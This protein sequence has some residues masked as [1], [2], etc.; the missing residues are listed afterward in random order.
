LRVLLVDDEAAVLSAVSRMLHVYEPS[1]EVRTAL[2]ADSA[3]QAL[4]EQPVDVVV[5]DV[6]MPKVPG[7]RF[8]AEVR[9]LYPGL[10]RILLTGHADRNA[11]LRSIGAAHRFLRK[12]CEPEELVRA[13]SE[14]YALRSLLNHPG[15]ERVAG[16]AKSLPAAPS[17]YIRLRQELDDPMCSAERVGTIMAMD[18]AMSAKVLQLV[19]SSFFGLAKAVTS[20][21]QACMVLGTDTLSSIVAMTDGFSR[22]GS[23]VVGGLSIEELQSHSLSVGTLSRKIAL[24]RPE[25]QAFGETAFLAGLLH[26]AGKLLLATAQK[27]YARILKA[28]IASKTPIDTIER[29]MW[30]SGHGEVGAYLLGL[31]GLPDPVVEAVAFHHRPLEAPSSGFNLASCVYLGD[32][33]CRHTSGDE[34]PYAAQELINRFELQEPIEEIAA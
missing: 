7:D 21:A 5:S 20:T 18:V 26:D 11:S 15:L 2:D 30:R 24:V 14:S 23:G 9:E 8:L 13:I 34:L 29:E 16:G 6:R 3:L 19:N 17:L 10:V 33:L 28:S 22:F 32:A 25:T 4:D 31:W 1:W 12:P 27:D